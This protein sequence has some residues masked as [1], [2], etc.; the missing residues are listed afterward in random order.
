MGRTR[1]PQKRSLF[2]AR[3]ATQSNLTHDSWDPYESV[4]PQTSTRFVQPCMQGTQRHRPRYCDIRSNRP[5]LA[6]DAGDTARTGKLTRPVLC[7]R[8]RSSLPTAGPATIPPVAIRTI[9]QSHR[10]RRTSGFVL[11]VGLFTEFFWSVNSSQKTAAVIIII[12]YPN[13]QTVN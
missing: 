7:E 2:P 1:P 12:I 13:E 3:F 10:A 5:H 9:S 11:L 8:I 6:P 4:C